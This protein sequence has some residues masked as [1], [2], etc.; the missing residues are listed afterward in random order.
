MGAQ[1]GGWS[2]KWGEASRSPERWDVRHLHFNNEGPKIRQRDAHNRMLAAEQG[3]LWVKVDLHSIH[4]HMFLDKKDSRGDG[5]CDTWTRS[6]CLILQFGI[7]VTNVFLK[8]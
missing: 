3:N 7:H 8:L 2:K 1:W 6:K 5:V 4:L